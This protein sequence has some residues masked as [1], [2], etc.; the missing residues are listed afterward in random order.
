MNRFDRFKRFD[1]SRRQEKGFTI[2]TVMGIGIVMVLIAAA[3]INRV[4]NDQAIAG[5]QFRSEG[6]INAAEIGITRLQ[7][8]LTQNRLFATQNSTQWETLV[9]NLNNEMAA[10][11]NLALHH[12]WQAGQ[13]YAQGQW[14]NAGQ[15]N[16]QYRMLSYNYRSQPGSNGQ[17]G[18]ATVMIEGQV[19]GGLRPAVSR[20][21]VE[22]PIATASSP[23]VPPALSA[24]SFNMD[25]ATRVTG[26]VRAHICPDLTDVDLVPGITNSNLTA[27]KITAGMDT[28][29]PLPQRAPASAISVPVITGNITL[30]RLADFPDS[31]GNF[32]YVVEADAL[33]NSIQLADDQKIMI[34]VADNQSV[35]LYVRGN[36]DLGGGQVN[37]PMAGETQPHPEK[38]RIYG[39]DRTLKFSLKDSASVMALIHVPL[40]I[41]SSGAAPKIGTGITGSLLIQQWD[42]ATQHSQLPIKQLGGQ[43]EQQLGI[44]LQ[45]ISSWQRQGQ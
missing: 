14:L 8:F 20:L 3:L 34:K 4:Q 18:L 6:A 2:P 7:S 36:V 19:T 21:A 24:K 31:Q 12:A 27:G 30:P 33:N 35:N 17:V 42:S 38:L 13:S 29:W 44:Q 22:I 16:H 39:S 11:P 28:F 23:P 43:P 5:M 10:C 41:G 25:S 40:A 32:D 45:P 15:A 9:A 1:R 26:D 37:M